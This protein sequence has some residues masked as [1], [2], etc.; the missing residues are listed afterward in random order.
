M[1]T[2]RLCHVPQQSGRYIVLWPEFSRSLEMTC[3]VLEVA[4]V[5]ATEATKIMCLEK[6]WI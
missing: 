2:E 5:P 4:R 3:C 6:F 1:E